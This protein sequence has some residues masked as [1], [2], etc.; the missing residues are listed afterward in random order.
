MRETWYYGPRSI[1]PNRKWRAPGTGKDGRPSTTGGEVE[2]GLTETGR[3]SQQGPHRSDYNIMTSDRQE[4][5]YH[6]PTGIKAKG[7]QTHCEKIIIGI[8]EQR[9]PAGNRKIYN[10]V[11]PCKKPDKRH[12]AGGGETCCRGEHGHRRIYNITSAKEG[13]E[14]FKGE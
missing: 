6:K 8:N 11:T 5:V 14:I 13:L 12:P 2:L 10:A 4:E 9:L 7:T 3:T 1:H